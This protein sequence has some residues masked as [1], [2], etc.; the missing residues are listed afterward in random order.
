MNHAYHFSDVTLLITHYNRSSSLERLL[1]GFAE[2]QVNFGEI[3]VSDDGSNVIHQ[4]KINSLCEEYNF[5]LVTTPVNKGLGNNLNKGQDAVKTPYTL[6]VQEDFVPTSVFPRHFQDAIEIMNA[7]KEMDIIKF[8]AYYSYPYLKNY[9]KGF[10]EMLFKPWFPGYTK[11]YYYSDHPHLRR[12]NFF[13]K[14]GRYVEGI[15]GDNTEYLMCIS[16]LRNKGK[17]LFYNDYKGLF[18][19]VNTELEPSTMK[20]NF[21]RESRN[22]FVNLARDMYRHL[23]LNYYLFISRPG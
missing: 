13:D 17:G 11:V 8:Y 16:F 12:S 23:K 9:A 4:E 5:R 20:R 14:F 21:W 6:Y 7:K 22:P 1:R 10:S 2:L 19:Q 15:S 3:I 18:N